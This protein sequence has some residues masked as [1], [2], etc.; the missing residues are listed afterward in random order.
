PTAGERCAESEEDRPRKVFDTGFAT[1]PVP[2]EA[3][4]CCGFCGKSRYEVPTLIQAAVGYICNECVKV[5]ADI[6]QKSAPSTTTTSAAVEVT[7]A[8]CKKQCDAGLL[9]CPT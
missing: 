5:C 8:G 1:T 2:A 9:L 3:A 6:I 7:C 4:A